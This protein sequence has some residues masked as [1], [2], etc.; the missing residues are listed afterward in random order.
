[1]QWRGA[2]ICYG[3]SVI[4]VSQA[5]LLDINWHFR[6]ILPIELANH[7]W[8]QL[9]HFGGIPVTLVESRT[10][11][12][13]HPQCQSITDCQRCCQITFLLHSNCRL[14][15]TL[16]V[17]IIGGRV[18]IVGISQSSTQNWDGPVQESSGGELQ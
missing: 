7:I 4:E 9:D 17:A 1:M 10:P 15:L 13:C 16:D 3:M 6:S 8:I 18:G 11:A 2:A 12:S 5:M 14:V